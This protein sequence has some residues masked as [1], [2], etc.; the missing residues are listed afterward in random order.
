MK[1]VPGVTAK[2]KNKALST[3]DIV[4]KIAGSRPDLEKAFAFYLGQRNY[5]VL[6]Q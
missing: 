2:A 5:N 3:G 4:V 6:P 1:N